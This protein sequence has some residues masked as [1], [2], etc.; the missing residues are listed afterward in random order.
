MKKQ[1]KVLMGFVNY[2]GEVDYEVIAIF[3]SENRAKQYI[4][5][6]ESDNYTN[7]IYKI[8]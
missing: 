7:V 2:L 3:Y 8:S 5:T 1:Y 4:K 6:C